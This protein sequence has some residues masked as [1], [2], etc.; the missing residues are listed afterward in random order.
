MNYQIIVDLE[1][2]ESFICEN[3][4]VGLWKIENEEGRQLLITSVAKINMYFAT[5]CYL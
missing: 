2:G 1:S 3:I 4:S 5:G